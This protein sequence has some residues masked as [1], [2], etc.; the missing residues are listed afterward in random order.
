MNASWNSPMKAHT[1][2][3]GKKPNTL[4]NQKRFKVKGSR[5][6]EIELEQI[7]AIARLFLGNKRI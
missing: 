7:K 2:Y 3:G 4:A 6:I 5:V 1:M